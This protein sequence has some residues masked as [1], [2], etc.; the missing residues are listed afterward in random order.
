MLD[1]RYLDGELG[2]SRGDY[3]AIYQGCMVASG[4]SAFSIFPGRTAHDIAPAAIL[5]AEAGGKVT[6]ID[7]E[8]HDFRSALHGAV[9]S[10]MIAHCAVI[11]LL[12]TDEL[13]SA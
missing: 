2:A 10:N 8:P 5:V 4:K 7:G 12:D 6:D 1:L 3:S 9:F 13:R 11:E